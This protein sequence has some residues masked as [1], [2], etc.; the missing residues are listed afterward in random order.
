MVY[1]LPLQNYSCNLFTTSVKL[2]APLK[3]VNEFIDLKNLS[4][5]KKN[6]DQ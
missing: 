6:I 1:N 5:N 4:F 3:L 2:C